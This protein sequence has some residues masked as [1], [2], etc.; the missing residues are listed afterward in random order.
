MAPWKKTIALWVTLIVLFV[1]FYQFY[2]VPP[3]PAAVQAAPGKSSSWLSI[4]FKLLPVIFIALFALFFWGA[5]RRNRETVEGLRLFREGRYVQALALYEKYRKAQPNQPLAAMNT[6][7]ARLFLWKLEQ[8]LVDLQEAQ[9]LLG[10]QEWEL[11]GM[12]LENLALTQALLGRAGDA[13]LTL[14]N[15]PDGK[16]D[17]SRVGLVEGILLA[18]TGDAAGARLKLG[19]FAVKQQGGSVGAMGRAVDG[20]CIETL[21]GERRHVD[22][23]ALFGETGPDELRKAWPELVAYVERAPAW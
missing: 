17:P 18:R 12:L 5:V 23:V 22:R 11:R 16:A 1:A 2:S 4:F 6:G 15:L 10:T 3:D 13:R 19:T 7:A 14:N 9:R 20:L 8:A 21:T